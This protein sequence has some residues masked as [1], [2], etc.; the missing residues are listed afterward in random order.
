MLTQLKRRQLE[1]AA[2]DGEG[3]AVF[4]FLGTDSSKD[5]KMVQGQ[6]K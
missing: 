4:T 2:Q 1:V 3:S 5:K 6:M